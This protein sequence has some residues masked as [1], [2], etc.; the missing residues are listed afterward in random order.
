MRSSFKEE[1]ENFLRCLKTYGAKTVHTL[2]AAFLVWLFGILVFIPLASTLNRQAK[3]LCSL[4]FFVAFTILL[5]RAIPG[6]K[7]LIDA[8]SVFPARKYGSKKGLSYENSLVMFRHIFYIISAV[9]VYLLY[10]PFLTNFHPAI[11]G[12]VLI[13]VLVWIFFLALRILTILRQKIL[14][15]LIT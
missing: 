6:L 14:G 10:L 7:K 13:L 12:I 11:S 3:A 9:I 2:L 1:I 15:W 4:I 5:L 8:F